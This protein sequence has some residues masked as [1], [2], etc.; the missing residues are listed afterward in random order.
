MRYDAVL[1]DM[2]GTVMETAPGV[3]NG[4]KYA[5]DKLNIPFP[6]V[7]ERLFLGPPLDYSFR[8]FVHIPEELIYPAEN[9]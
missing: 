6:D 5:L 9:R 2:D 1:F 4:F 3:I 8:E 7:Q